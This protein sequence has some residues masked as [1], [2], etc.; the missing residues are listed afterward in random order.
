MA[1]PDFPR[2]E[3]D[4]IELANTMQT[5]GWLLI[6]RRIKQM[7]MEGGQRLEGGGKDRHDLNLGYLNGV[8]EVLKR[9]RAWF[10]EAQ[11]FIAKERA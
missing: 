4:A 6:E 3:V 1:E 10:E 11:S 8:R 5:P 7:V 9:S 2:G